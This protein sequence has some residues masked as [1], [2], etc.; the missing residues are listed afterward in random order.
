MK[1]ASRPLERGLDRRS[2]LTG[3]TALVTLAGCRAAPRSPARTDREAE[4]DA[5]LDELFADLEDA[6][7]TIPPISSEEKRGRVARLA[8][9]LAAHGIDALLVEPGATLDYLSGVSWWMSERLFALVVCADGSAFWIAPAFE[10]PRAA[11]EIAAVGP[12]APLVTWD[13]HEYAWRPLERA[14]AERGCATIA[15]DP[16]ARAFVVHALGEVLGPER[17][18]PGLAVV[19]DLRGRKEPRELALLRRASELTQRAIAAVAERLRPGTTDHQLG[20]MLRR[21][22]ERLGLANTWALSLVGPGA[23]LPHGSAEGRVLAPGDLVLVDTGGALHDYQ[24]DVSRTWIFA[25]EPARDVR[26]AWNAVRAAQLRA[27]DT[28]R[29]GVPCRDV[30]RAARTVIEAAGF[31]AGYASFAHRLGHGI[32]LEGHEEPYFD[33]GSEVRC[34]PGMTFSD[35]PGIYVPGRFGVRLEDIV[36]VTEDGADHFGSWQ[37]TWSAPRSS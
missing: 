4:E 30:D 16:R 29:P 22:Q 13:E 23:A 14:L 11:A 27:F 25:G 1:H 19:R 10:A 24:S 3:A 31:G 26:S 32:G 35:E 2:L 37:D 7:G 18:L 15:V 21:A 20:A 6:S 17:V 5:R 12:A 33:G 34:E 28:I 8:G 9:V 36:V